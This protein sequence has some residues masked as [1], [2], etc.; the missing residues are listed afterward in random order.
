MP[1]IYLLFL[2]GLPNRKIVYKRLKLKKKKNPEI[3]ILSITEDNF[4]VLLKNTFMFGCLFVLDILLDLHMICIIFLFC[5][6][7]SKTSLQYFYLTVFIFHTKSFFFG[8]RRLFTKTHNFGR[9]NLSN[10]NLISY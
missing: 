3:Y 9:K 1:S 7:S 6:N 4:Y 5:L 8:F 2:R 10:S